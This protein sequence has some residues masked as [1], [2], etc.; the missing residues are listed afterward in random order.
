MSFFVKFVRILSKAPPHKGQY[1][2]CSASD[3]LSFVRCCPKKP[4]A[5]RRGLECLSE[6]PDGECDQSD[7]AFEDAE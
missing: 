2:I 5:L 6:L 3:A 4:P 1:A 7:N